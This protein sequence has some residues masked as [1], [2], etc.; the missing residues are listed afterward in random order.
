MRSSDLTTELARFT[1][2][3][4]LLASIERRVGALQSLRETARLAGPSR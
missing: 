1:P 3:A 2:A 4:D